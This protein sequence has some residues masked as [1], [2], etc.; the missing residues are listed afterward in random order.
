MPDNPEL[1]R[2]RPRRER[3]TGGGIPR[4]PWRRIVNPF[5]PLEL[6]SADQVEAVHRAGL[7]IL[8]DVGV[9]VL[10][11]AALDRFA[12]AG[13]SVQREGDTAGRGA[14]GA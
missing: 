14:S 8:R 12:R 11:A 1:L 5:T 13:A 7:Q 9:E 6:L 2:T 4:L 10:N 3:R